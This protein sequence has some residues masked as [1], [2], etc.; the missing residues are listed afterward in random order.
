MVR[1][2]DPSTLPTPP[3]AVVGDLLF[4]IVAHDDAGAELA[5]LPAEVNLSARYT[6]QQL[7]G[8]NRQDVTLAWLDAAAGQWR[9]A[10]KLV[11]SPATNYVAASVTALGA[12]AVCAS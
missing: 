5:Q 8:L 12:Y 4:E 7:S 1:L 6:N 2:V 10:P 11:T 9:T 3:C